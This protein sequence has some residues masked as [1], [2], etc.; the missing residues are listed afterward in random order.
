MV[1][2]STPS[3]LRPR[4]VPSIRLPLATSVRRCRALPRLVLHVDFPLPRRVGSRRRGRSLRGRLRRASQHLGNPAPG[5]YLIA[6]PNRRRTHAERRA[7]SLGVRHDARLARHQ[8]VVDLARRDANPLRIPFNDHG[9][10]RAGALGLLHAGRDAWHARDL[11]ADLL[12]PGLPLLE[13]GVEVAAG[14]DIDRREHADDLLLADLHHAAERVMRGAVHE[15]R[16]DEVLPAEQQT[17]A[18]RAAQ[19]LAAAV[20]DQIGA[21]RESRG[22]VA[23]GAPRPR[24]Q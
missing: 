11:I 5:E 3:S 1:P 20:G 12:Q 7:V 4:C 6:F 17:G 24:R 14:E 8:L 22:S 21:A 13:I 15:R 23:S 19:R 16:P 9:R 10:I 2:L 18:L